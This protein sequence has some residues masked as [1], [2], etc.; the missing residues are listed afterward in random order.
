MKKMILIAGIFTASFISANTITVEK[1]S[2]KKLQNN[3]EVVSNK[4]IAKTSKAKTK[5]QRQC[6]AV[7]VTCTSAYTCQDW[8]PEQWMNWA[9][10]IQYNYCD[11]NSP[12]HV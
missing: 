1:K 9:D 8:T 4:Q 3:K 2:D 11:I 10:Q 5:K 6:L 12:L 7:S